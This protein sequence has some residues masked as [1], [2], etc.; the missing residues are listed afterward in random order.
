MNNASKGRCVTVTPRG[1]K[2]FAIADIRFGFRPLI[3]F[4]SQIA[5]RNSQ[6]NDARY[7]VDAMSLE[8][9]PIREN[10]TRSR[11]ALT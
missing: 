7:A 8:A 2:G 6:M 9:Q 11:I 5:I 3:L 10:F 1:K 4:R